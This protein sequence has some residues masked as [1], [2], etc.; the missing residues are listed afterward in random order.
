MKEWK[1]EKKAAQQSKPFWK[2]IRDVLLE[3]LKGAAVKAAL[4]KLL[5]SATMG[6]F[7]AWVIKFIVTELFEEVAE[8][9]IKL[10]F[11]KGML[12]YDKADGRMKLKKIRKSKDENDADTY[13]DTISDI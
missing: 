3:Q 12:I 7:Q 9:L 5:G 8:P 1:V 2:R 11:R 6:G 10:T 13:W 4:K